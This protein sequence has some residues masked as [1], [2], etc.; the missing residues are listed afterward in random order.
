MCLP[1]PLERRWTATPLALGEDLHGTAGETRLDLGAG[2]AVRNAVEVALDIDVVIDADTTNAPFGEDVGLD[3]QRL[4]RRPVELFEELPARAADPTDGALLV[5]PPEQLADGRVEL[6]E[7][8][9]P[10]IAQLRQNP[11]LND[12][13]RGLDL[14]PYRAADGAGLV[15]RRCRNA[16]PSRH[17]FG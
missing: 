2:E 13:N 9:E 6:S 14:W 8:V 15:A 4:E 3:R 11:P 17:R 12:E 5:E 1:L 10:S 16:P 7:A